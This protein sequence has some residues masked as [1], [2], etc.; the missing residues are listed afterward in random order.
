M[1]YQPSRLPRFLTLLQF[2]Q[3]QKELSV[4]VQKAVA[5]I[6][7]Q[8]KKD[9]GLRGSRYQMARSYRGLREQFHQV[10]LNIANI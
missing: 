9:L 6:F 4:F 8:K 1:P 10:K 3:S 7:S 5:Q 2:L